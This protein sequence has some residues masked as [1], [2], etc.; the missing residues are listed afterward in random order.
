MLGT[1]FAT[2]STSDSGIAIARPTSR[3]AALAASRPK[4]TI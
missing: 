4:V 2:L 1:S 3:M